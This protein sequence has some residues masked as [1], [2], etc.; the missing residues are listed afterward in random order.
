MPVIEVVL[1]IVKLYLSVAKVKDEVSL[2]VYNF[3]SELIS[4]SYSETFGSIKMIDLKYT[5]LLH[6]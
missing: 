5:Y 2:K 1:G 3:I 4:S 6:V